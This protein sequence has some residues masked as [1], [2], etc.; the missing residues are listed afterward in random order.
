[1]KAVI[2]IDSFK[3]S[4][5]SIEAGNAVK[6]AYLDVLGGKA[7]V[8]PVSDGGEGTTETLLTAF[9]GKRVTR[10]VT[11]PLGEP[12]EAFYGI[13]NEGKTAVLEM[14]VAAGLPL[15]PPNFQNPMNTTTYGV[16]E[17][18]LDAMDQGV[19]EFV[20]G[21][22]GSATNDGGLGMLSALGIQFLDKEGK[23]CGIYGKDVENVAGICQD[24]MDPRL[25]DCTFRVAC[26]VTNPLCGENGASAVFGP[27]K[28]ADAAM[29]KRLDRGLS[30][31]ADLT[32]QLLKGSFRDMPG[33]GAAGGLGFALLAFLKAELVPGIEL[34]LDLLRVEKEMKTADL[35]ITGEGRIDGQTAMGKT[36]VGVAALAK[37]HAKPVIAFGGCI[38]EGAQACNEKGI[39]AYFPILRDMLSKE[40]A[41]DPET[42]REN[43]YQTAVQI[44]RFTKALLYRNIQ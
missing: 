11:G 23:R 10:T 28:G 26:D 12:V 33:A 6:Q 5:T 22:G 2:A 44:F 17:L 7:V 36:P 14:A 16:G 25:Q 39:D 35:V 31:Y 18:I 21:I 37:R 4:L 29:I 19:R 30:K 8:Y 32:E 3:G 24:G 15:V 13:V 20:L 9:H 40:E 42:A 34:V 38:G 1:M 41:M 43:L 27:Q